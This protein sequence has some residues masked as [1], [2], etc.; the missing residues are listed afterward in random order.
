MA[1]VRWCDD[2]LHY[3]GENKEVPSLVAALP[4]ICNDPYAL[5]VSQERFLGILDKYQYQ[6]QLLDPFFEKLIAQLFQLAH[7]Q[8]EAPPTSRHQAFKYLY[9]LSKLRG[10]KVI[11]RWFSHEVSELVPVLEL[12]QQQ[13]TKDVA[14]WE[15]RYILLLWLSIIIIMP[16]DLSRM[17][18]P[19]QPG[20]TPKQRIVDRMYDI[21]KLYLAVSDKS[22]DAATT[23]LAKLLSRPDVIQQKMNEFLEWSFTTLTTVDKYVM[24]GIQGIPVVTGILKTLS[25]LF[26]I[27]KREDMVSYAPR[28]LELL[29]G[30]GLSQSYNTQLRKLN[31]KL[32]QR[33][34]M[35]FL[36]SRVASWR[37]Q[38]G[39]R[40]LAETL[41]STTPSSQPLQPHQEEDDDGYEIPEQIEDV[42]ELLLTG[43]RDNDTIVRWSAAK[44]IGRLTGRLP[45]ELAD[46]VVESLLD[47][48]SVRDS[49][50]AWHGGC[51]ALAELGRRGLLLPQRLPKVVPVVLKALIYD[52]R[53]GLSSVGAHVRDSACYV[54]WSFARAYEPNELKPYVNDIARALV[55]TT[56]F[57]REVNCRRAASAAFQ[58]NVGRQ[59]TFPHGIDILTASDYF[60]VGSR[61]NA[62][63]HV[64]VY[65]AQFSEYTCSLI[66]HLLAEKL[67]HWD[68]SV[69]EL[70][71]EALRNITHRDPSYIREQVLPSLLPL[72]MS[73]DPA[74]QHGALRA[75]SELTFAL[76][77]LDSSST[78]QQTLGDD[79]IAQLLDIAPK[80]V[81]AK[82]FKGMTGEI[83]IPAVLKYFERMSLCGLHTYTPVVVETWQ[84]IIDDN[85]PHLDENIRLCAASALT[86][87]CESH[88]CL[89][90]D[91]VKATQSALVPRYIS[92]LTSDNHLDRMGFSLALRGLPLPLLQGQLEP[93]LD[94]LGKCIGDI[95]GVDTKFTESRRDAIYAVTSIATKVGVSSD[96]SCDVSCDLCPGNLEAVFEMLFTGLADYTVDGRG[97]V[98]ALVREA[99]MQGIGDVLLKI[100]DSGHSE[101]IT[102]EIC[103]KAMCCLLQQAN[104]KIDRTRG[105]ALTTLTALVL[106]TPTLPHIPHHTHLKEIFCKTDMDIV[107]WSV[108]QT[109]FPLTVQLLA[110][111]DYSYPTLLGLVISVGGLTESTVRQSSASL[112]SYLRSVTSDPS[113]LESFTTPL[114]KVFGDNVKNNRVILPLF[115]TLDL[116]LSNGVFEV[117]SQGDH[118][119]PSLLLELMKQEVKNSKDA[120]KLLSSI[121]VFCGLLQFPEVRQATLNHVMILLC[122]RIPAVRKMTADQLYITLVTFDDIIDTEVMEEVIS[123]LS[124]TAWDGGIVSVREQR[125]IICDLLKL[126][127]P[128]LVAKT[129]SGKTSSKKPKDDFDSY[130]DLVD[131]AASGY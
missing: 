32:T 48:F 117:L 42:L 50:A 20:H 130:R 120:T 54:C 27:T 85:I 70:A 67:K 2:P 99:S 103:R 36:A 129:S 116:L 90:Q 115:K 56:V 8:H 16:F 37:Y 14:K 64:S 97:D 69:R 82:V 21:G 61:A 100:I 78:L 118:D 113:T 52:E 73:P 74:L 89:Y 76:Y 22:G 101:I 112:L 71:A 41:K 83:L 45:K 98:G 15:S 49:D 87:L 108:P 63:T 119:F 65:V 126:A 114:I 125:N 18:T 3:F 28:V 124:D 46:D 122:H 62:Y 102:P 110:L 53:R 33:L 4:Q 91:T 106:H 111:P 58:E 55:I 11:V 25:T 9:Y 30:C 34:G 68:I 5:E 94:S 72:V 26:K 31:I 131:R 12:L 38:R 96:V 95:E 123:I 13:N 121:N 84:S 109:T 107:N 51:L 29:S 60:A 1:E 75:V 93:I 40:S 80:L 104:E 10:S 6:P 23:M 92:S 105:V 39:S 19:I 86:Q 66:D 59:G 44:G 7:P 79:I 57:D 77:E 81:A 17:D 88:Y 47:F 128:K 35:T 43:L 24:L 127:R